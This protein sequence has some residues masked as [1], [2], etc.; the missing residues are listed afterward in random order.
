[1]NEEL[2]VKKIAGVNS[3]AIHTLCVEILDYKEKIK[4]AL[5]NITDTFDE[6]Q[7]YLSGDLKE[8]LTSKYNALKMSYDVIVA[9]VDSYID[10]YNALLVAEANFDLEAAAKLNTAVSSLDNEGDER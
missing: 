4:N 7:E 6:S 1:M 3:D 8:E 9:N 2:E 5:Q 10:E